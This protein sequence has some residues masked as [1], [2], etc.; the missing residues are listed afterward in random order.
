ME[1]SQFWKRKIREGAI[2]NPVDRTAE[3]L[4]GL[5]MVLSFTGTISVASDGRQEIKDLLLAA[6]GCNLA[7]GLVDAIMYIMNVLIERG[8]AR[9]IVNKIQQTGNPEDRRE[10]LRGEM[11]PVIAELL[12]DGEADYINGR[13]RELPPPEKRML[14]TNRDLISGLEIFLLVFFCT[15]PV[16]LP[17]VFLN[18]VSIAL[19]T[20][21]AI[22]LMQLFIGGFILARYAGFRPM[23]TAIAY[24]LIGALLVALT[25]ALGG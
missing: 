1:D 25:M 8:H 21:N 18:N 16:A 14:F 20:S 2:L 13:I 24:M 19:R 6:L 11:Q 3:V 17:F 12:R 7:W 5:I 9:L 4:F 22:A 10:I 15:L 23:R